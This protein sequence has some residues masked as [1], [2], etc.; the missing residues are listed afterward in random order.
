MLI[1]TKVR[2]AKSSR[3]K[4]WINI[5]KSCASLSSK[6]ETRGK[7]HLLSKQCFMHKFRFLK[8]ARQFKQRKCVWVHSFRRKKFCCQ[9]KQCWSQMLCL[10]WCLSLYSLITFF[11]SL[12]VFFSSCMLLFFHQLS[13]HVFL[14]LSLDNF[15]KLLSLFDHALNLYM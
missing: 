8:A 7:R 2:N 13:L 11:L 15:L 14:F 5:F 3:V 9:D 4:L 1:I 12:L 10:A 6:Y